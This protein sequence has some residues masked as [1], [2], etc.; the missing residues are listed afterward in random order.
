MATTRDGSSPRDYADSNKTGGAISRLSATVSQ[1]P[2]INHG[3]RAGP[4]A[5]KLVKSTGRAAWYFVTT[6]LILVVPLALEM[7]REQMLKALEQQESGGPY[8]LSVHK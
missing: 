1:S 3:K 2:I 8:R 7:D 6:I 5:K 4:V